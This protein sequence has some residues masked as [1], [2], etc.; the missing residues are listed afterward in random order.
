MNFSRI[1]RSGTMQA[2]PIGTVQHRRDE[3]VTRRSNTSRANELENLV[4]FSKTHRVSVDARY[5]PGLARKRFPI[6][7]SSN[8]I[9]RRQSVDPCS[10]P[11]A[12]SAT[13]CVPGSADVLVS[14]PNGSTASE[15]I[16]Q[17]A[18]LVPSRRVIQRVA[19]TFDPRSRM[20][21][22]QHLHDLLRSE[23]PGQ[24]QSPPDLAGARTGRSGG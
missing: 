10:D 9:L 5:S 20:H 13:L 14:A 7:R 16:E 11:V 1:P 6:D 2:R 3:Y 17:T 18:K 12:V 19:H 23:H 24:R 15:G 21:L 8:E 4:W 22:P